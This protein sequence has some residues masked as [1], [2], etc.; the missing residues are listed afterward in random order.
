MKTK[1]KFFLP[2]F[3]LA[4][5]L[6]SCD[7]PVC[8]NTN[9]VFDKYS[10]DSEEY[11]SELVKQLGIVDKTKLSYWFSEYVESAGKELLYFRIQGDGLCAKIVL[12]VDQWNKLDELRQKK[13]ET[14]IG[15]EFVNLK[16]E[17]VQDS[18]KTEFKY[19][20]FDRIID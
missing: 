19:I 16:F 3:C 2:L 4:I 18:L 1:I 9:P 10:P 7:R 11:K 14:F 13:G 20:D 5:L 12:N 6:F 17:I 8:K 15:A